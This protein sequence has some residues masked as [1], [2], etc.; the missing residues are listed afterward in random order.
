MRDRIQNICQQGA[1]EEQRQ[2]RDAALLLQD[3]VVERGKRLQQQLP[4]HLLHEVADLRLVIPDVQQ[5][6]HDVEQPF[7]G[8]STSP[9]V[10]AWLTC[11]VLVLHGDGPILS[12]GDQ[13]LLV[14]VP[15]A[16]LA[17]DHAVSQLH[18]SQ[19]VLAHALCVLRGVVCTPSREETDL[20]ALLVQ[21]NPL[22]VELVIHHERLSLEQLSRRLELILH[23]SRQH[24][25]EDLPDRHHMLPGRQRVLVALQDVL[26]Q[27]PQVKV[28]VQNFHG[29][30]MVA[31]QNTLLG[32]SQPHV[33]GASVMPSPRNRGLS[34]EAPLTPRIM[35]KI[36]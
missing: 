5:I 23:P 6:E 1:T 20:L 13:L 16:H 4:L 2:V 22:P 30:R 3:V 29:P 32:H 34:C 35:R 24:G 8:P 33:L 14:V 12:E 27:D 25:L 26:A 19:D 28:L 36:Q 11:F 9:R 21:Q 15:G 7:R 17:V 10:K 18:A 31:M